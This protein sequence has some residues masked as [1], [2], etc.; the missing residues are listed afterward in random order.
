MFW[1]SACA[2]TYSY[3]MYPLL[4]LAMPAGRRR[5]VAESRTLPS[6]SL[7]VTVYNES[8]RIREKVHN[9]L[10]LDYPG[11]ELIV[12]SDC[13][14]DDTDDIVL[15][16]ADRGVRLVRAS[17]RLGKEN[18]QL[19]AIKENQCEILV[20]SDV[21][22]Q[23]PREALRALARY[24]DDPS[25]G[26]I[27]SED[28]FIAQDGKVAGEGAYVRYEMWLR[29]MESCRAGLVGLSGSFFAA[30]KSVCDLWDIHSPSDFN[31]ALTCVRLGLR[32]ITAPDV[33]GYYKDLKDPKLEY[34]RKVRTVLRGM[35]AITRH[36]E[37]L[38]P[39]QFG[40]FAWQVWSHKVMRW[41]VPF[42]LVALFLS[43]L[44]LFSTHWFYAF[45]LLAQVVFYGAAVVAHRWVP[46]REF[47]PVRLVYFFVQVN[48]AIADAFW[49]LC[50]G[51]RMTTWQ[52]STR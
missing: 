15:E 12:T 11:I 39:L 32:A 52:P 22:T 24:F 21:A 33:L 25:V 26:A 9:T 2:A 13:S 5:P 31:T 44:A 36:P 17:A 50:R 8:A 49:R 4:L 18:A 30:R 40:S 41:S 38:N 28:R 48:V 6:M 10:A 19:C 7:V 3:F 37:V 27:S 14:S 1:L 20:F 42:A 51:N 46:A 34:E 29:R 45:A 47:G 16:Y 43:S 23:I 35:T